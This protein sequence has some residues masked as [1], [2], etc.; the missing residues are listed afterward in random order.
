MSRYPEQHAGKGL[1]VGES[2][3]KIPHLEEENPVTKTILAMS[4][5]CQEQ[6]VRNMVKLHMSRGERM[7]LALLSGDA[8]C[9]KSYAVSLLEKKLKSMNVSVA[10]SAMTNK[11]AGTLMESGSLDRVYTFHKMMGFKQDLLDEKLSL[12]DFT[13]QYN[14]VH[15]NAISHFNSLRQSNPRDT[16]GMDS[17]HSCAHLRPESCAVCSNTFKQL[18]LSQKH[19]EPDPPPFLGMNVLIVDEYARGIYSTPLFV[20]RRQ[21]KDPGYAEALTYLQFN[22]VTE[23]SQ[24]IFRSQVSVSELDVMDPGYEPEKLRIFH[25]DKQQITY[26]AACMNKMGK[27]ARMGEKFLSV[28][29]NRSSHKGPTAWYEVLKQAAQTLPKLFSTP[30]YL[31]GVRLTERDYLTLDKLWVGCKVRMIWH[32]NDN[33]IQVAPDRNLLGKPG[34]RQRQRRQR[35]EQQQLSSMVDTEGVVRRIRYNHQSQFNEFY[36]KGEQTGT[37]YKVSPSTWNYM[38]WTVTTHPLACLLAMNTYDCQGCTVTGKVL[39]HPPRNFSMSPI[40]PSVYVVLTR[41]VMRENLQMTNCN[42][43]ETIG[44]VQFY[45]DRL[46]SYRKRVEMNYSS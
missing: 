12:K 7:K 15:W 43:A 38:N 8:G 18:M 32:M 2:Q 45:D 16:N 10:V 19:P 17:R 13:Q 21:F 4:R 23:E 6:W 42:F 26:T 40:K 29:R 11:A 31:K 35:R 30:K 28:T 44:A 22:T 24:R 25:Q 33:G 20:N 5:Y 3:S 34:E 14:R 9:G 37:L 39:Y 1:S 41:V 46:A 36:V 27:D